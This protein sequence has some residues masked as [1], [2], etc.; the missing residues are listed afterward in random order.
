V[1]D[2]LGSPKHLKESITIIVPVANASLR[3]QGW[4]LGSE[5]AEIL[6]VSPNY[7]RRLVNLD[8]LNPRRIGTTLVYSLSEVED[9]K[10]SHP[11]LAQR[12]GS[13]KD[14]GLKPAEDDP[15]LAMRG[16]GKELWIDLGSDEYVAT[17]RTGWDG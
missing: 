10:A 16:V 13:S 7:I 1:P 6:G 5:A 11:R 8:R 2:V 4:I 15:V 14:E 12:R 17:L 3:S 9:Y